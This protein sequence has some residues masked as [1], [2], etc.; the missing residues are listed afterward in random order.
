MDC[1][2]DTSINYPK[3]EDEDDNPKKNIEVKAKK[4]HWTRNTQQ[5][6]QNVHWRW[7]A[8]TPNA[9]RHSIRRLSS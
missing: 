1:A 3:N 4:K 7:Q 9:I 8:R 5:V 6:G 2:F